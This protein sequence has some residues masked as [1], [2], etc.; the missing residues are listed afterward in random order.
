VKHSAVTAPLRKPAG[1]TF[2]IEALHLRSF[3]FLARAIGFW[4]HRMR[5]IACPECGVVGSLD[6]DIRSYGARFTCD[7]CVF[8]DLEVFEARRPGRPRPSGA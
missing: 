8:E 1:P 7:N 5:G 6:I 4:T 2:A 3:A